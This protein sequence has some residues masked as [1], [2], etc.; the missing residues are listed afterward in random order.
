MAGRSGGHAELVNYHYVTSTQRD[1]LDILQ[2]RDGRTHQTGNT[3]LTSYYIYGKPVLAPAAGTVT[4]ILDGRPDQAIGSTDNRFQ[5]GNNI[6]IDIGG[7]RF[8]LMGASQP[9]QHPGQGRRSGHA[10][11]TDCPGGNSGNTSEPHLHIQAQS[12]GT[13]IGDIATMDV[14]TIIRTLHTYPLVF[15][16]MVLTRRGT[17][18]QPASANPRRGDLLRSAS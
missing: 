2:T 6:V 13:G 10:R 12:A 7:G 16:H 14:P 15:S 4:F 5:S 17:E 18:S 3:E 8:L 1:A 9:R 11:P